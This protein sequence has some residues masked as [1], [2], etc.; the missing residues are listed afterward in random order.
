MGGRWSAAEFGKG[1]C[2]SEDRKA[3]EMVQM[4]VGR[5]LSG[6]AGSNPS[7]KASKRHRSTQQGRNKSRKVAF[8]FIDLYKRY[9]LS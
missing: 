7:L 4:E 3:G 8:L 6:R 1:L 2:C 9:R 5:G